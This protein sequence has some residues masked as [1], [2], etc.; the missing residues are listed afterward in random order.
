MAQGGLPKDHPVYL[1]ILQ[2]LNHLRR[3]ENRPEV[4]ELPSEWVHLSAAHLNAISIRL[5]TEIKAHRQYISEAHRFNLPPFDQII[6]N[7]TEYNLYQYNLQKVLINLPQ[8]TSV[9]PDLI[10]SK[11]KSYYFPDG[12]IPDHEVF[13][14][15]TDCRLVNTPTYV[16]VNK[17]YLAS[18]TINQSITSPNLSSEFS[19][20]PSS[21]P[22]NLSEELHN[23]DIEGLNLEGDTTRRRIESVSS[24]STQSL[25]DQESVIVRQQFTPRK[26]PSPFKDPPPIPPYR[27]RNPA[28]EEAQRRIEAL[29]RE[30]AALAASLQKSTAQPK[31][32]KTERQEIGDLKTQVN[33]M[34]N[35]LKLMTVN[36]PLNATTASERLLVNR[37]NETTVEETTAVAPSNAFVTL[38]RPTNIIPATQA[39]D[40]VSLPCLK[41]SAIIN[42]IGTFDPDTT[43]D[44]DFRCIWDRILDQTRNYKLYEHEYIMCLRVVMKGQAGMNLDK[45]IKEYGGDLNLVLEAIQD[46]FIPQHTIFDELT[47]LNGFKRKAGEHMRTMVRRASLLIYKLR[48]TVAPAA[49]ADR[50]HTLLSQIIKQ[51]IDKQTFAHLRSEELKCAQMGQHLSIE[52]ITNIV[53]FYET[54]NDLIPKTEIKL[55]YDVQTMKLKNQPDVHKSEID[56]LRK[57]LASLKASVLAPKRRKL[58]TTADKSTMPPSQQ[59]RG[60][61]IIKPKRRFGERMDTATDPPVQQ[62]RGQKRPN[63]SFNANKQY[64]YSSQ[65]QPQTH[66]QG[67][68]SQPQQRSRQRFSKSSNQ[69]V[70][71]GS[72]SQYS[73]PAQYRPLTYYNSYNSGK[74]NYNKRQNNYRSK[75]P[76]RGRSPY[77]SN[78]ES[79]RSYNFKGKKHDV[80]LNFYK[81][82]ICP[83]AHAEGTS[84][85]S[86][87]A[88]PYDPN[89]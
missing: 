19:N 25:T 50:R 3:L 82:S 11:D 16:S 57:E 38:E 65:P 85:A 26:N 52:A 29:E 31:A 80:S 37:F 77:R 48:A 30:K 13:V 59:P 63:D 18:H 66:S 84:C 53:E 34:M 40:P 78:S 72:Q 20:I 42:T 76:Y 22:L 51:V 39:R 33:E 87:K 43:P 73:A 7:E 69:N 24:V 68:T 23:L 2:D 32:V 15:D 89:E 28:M 4:T 21:T 70:R 75:S 67:Q 27:P 47:D 88:L 58:D 10:A 64:S 74:P 83:D 44:I 17:H 6:F 9:F 71:S 36:Q 61:T 81:C 49:W 5:K 1:N 79:R 60:R 8:E 56:T 46:L 14:T 54:S 12:V 86:Q 41:P 62:P 55:Q 45:M 35:L